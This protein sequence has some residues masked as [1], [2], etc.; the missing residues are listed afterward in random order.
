MCANL[1]NAKKKKKQNKQCSSRK[2]PTMKYLTTI[3]AFTKT[4]ALKYIQVP[5]SLPIFMR[6][7]GFKYNIQM[8]RAQRVSSFI[9]KKRKRNVCA[10]PPGYRG[11]RLPTVTWEGL[12]ILIVPIKPIY[13]RAVMA[14][15]IGVSATVAVSFQ[16]PEPPAHAQNR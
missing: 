1:S 10:P 2:C 12:I 9:E 6:C 15:V 14:I 11:W 5:E 13:N 4:H 3:S 8:S 16:E 7:S